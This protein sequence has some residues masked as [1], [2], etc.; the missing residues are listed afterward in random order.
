MEKYTKEQLL[1]KLSSGHLKESETIEFKEQW[2]QNSGRSISAIGNGEK[3]GWLIIGVNDNRRVIN[4]E[5]NWTKKQIELIEN[6]II[7]YL[8]PNATVQF[9]SSESIDS[10]SIV[11]IEIINS[12]SIVA[13]DNKFY[14]QVGSSTT[15][16]TPKEIKR[17]ELKRP[18]FDFSNLECDSETDNSLVLD[19]AKFLK[20]D[21]GDWTKLPSEEILSKL[22]IKNKNASRIL[23]GDF[24][25]RLIHYNNTSEVLD[26][27]E[28]KGLYKLLKEDFIQ[29][30]QSWTRVKPISL[31]PGSLSVAEEKP[32]SDDALR[33]ILVN[34]VAHSAFEKR[35]GGI[36]VEL[37]PN[38]I[39][40]SNHCLREAE[41]FINKIFSRNS[42]SYNPLLM[43][44]LRRANLSEE[45]GTG[46]DKIFK[47]VIENGNREPIFEYKEIPKNYGV[48]SV[49]LYNE[50]LNTN[51]LKLLDK[52]KTQ[53]EDE[54]DKYKLS[55][56]LVL[57]KDKYLE[58][59]LSYVDE[60]H[61]KLILEILTEEHSPV[62]YT[63]IASGTK[64][65]RIKINLKRWSALQLQGQESKV[66]SEGEENVAKERVRDHAYKKHR[67]GY[68]TNREARHLLGLSDSKSEQVQVS[69][70]F[71]K[72]EKA[73]FIEKSK[74]RG[75]WRVTEKFDD[76]YASVLEYLI[77]RLEDKSSK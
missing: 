9:I 69:T 5:A 3:G 32:Y 20:K 53:Y 23:F 14:K 41:V 36:K 47:Y 8:E 48:W 39:T 67:N 15:E 68:I 50:K 26:Q 51:L 17:L 64:E 10:N 30:I 75:S 13:W 24:V 70:L 61:K 65:K 40:I 4:R 49:T 33:E 35:K 27:E 56:A 34:A 58:E 1:E 28:R 74:K 60:Y 57:W 22:S 42:F 71:K 55:V 25:F 43:K 16:M 31:I 7:Q 2:T 21:N 46:K 52:L 29:H 11:I 59:I 54:I 77:S 6:H 63:S 37:Y 44:T 73:R 45:L 18:E 62:S 76:K 72:W 66:F 38:R 12:K 19:F